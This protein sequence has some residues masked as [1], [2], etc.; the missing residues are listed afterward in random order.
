M[1]NSN[2]RIRVAIENGIMK[3]SEEDRDKLLDELRPKGEWVWDK[4]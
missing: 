2:F 1:S 3:I 4:Y